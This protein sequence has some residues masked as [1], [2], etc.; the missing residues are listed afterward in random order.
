MVKAPDLSNVFLTRQGAKIPPTDCLAGT[1]AAV[2]QEQLDRPIPAAPDPKDPS[3]LQQVG[4]FEF[5]VQY[6][7]TKVC[8][9]IQPSGFWATSGQ[10]TCLIEDSVT[11]P[12]TENVARIGCVTIGKTEWADTNTPDGRLF[13][14]VIVRPQPEIY[15][16]AKPDQDNGVVISIANV[17]R[18]RCRSSVILAMFWTPPI[19]RRFPPFRRSLRPS[20]APRS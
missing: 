5:E 1:D 2:L 18:I 10:V 13:A 17:N 16:Q 8:V 4:A 19:I 9:E 20:C 7:S 3:I 15:S 14:Q 11:K 12:Q 6:D